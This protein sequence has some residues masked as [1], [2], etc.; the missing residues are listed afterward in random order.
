M[1]PGEYL[2]KNLEHIAINRHLKEEVFASALYRDRNTYVL[3][4]LAPLELFMRGS[5]GE[6]EEAMAENVG[7]RKEREIKGNISN[8]PLEN[9]EYYI[10]I[11]GVSIGKGEGRESHF[12]YEP[13]ASGDWR[14]ARS[15]EAEASFDDKLLQSTEKGFIMPVE[16]PKEALEK[17]FDSES[18]KEN[19][20]ELLMELPQWDAEPET[21]ATREQKEREFFEA[22]RKQ[23][24]IPEPLKSKPMALADLIFKCS[25]MPELCE[26]KLFKLIIESYMKN[27]ITRTKLELPFGEY[28]EGVLICDDQGKSLTEKILV[29]G[30][31]CCKH[32]EKTP[33]GKKEV[34]ILYET[35]N[36]VLAMPMFYT[37]EYL[38]GQEYERFIDNYPRLQAQ[39]G[40]HGYN[41]YKCFA[42]YVDENSMQAAIELFQIVVTHLCNE[43]YVLIE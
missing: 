40:T 41:L 24:A 35:I 1:K 18:F 32:P 29:E 22:L 43:E 31:V 39:K 12:R 28:A 36:N 11:N 2:F 33:E 20:V 38:E 19:M 14:I 7:R 15:R 34:Y 13:T 37:T 25:G 3:E 26:I 17:I 5:E 10:E 21:M 6:S 30:V 8:W 9:A 16:S 4:L 42:G 23:L 27:Y